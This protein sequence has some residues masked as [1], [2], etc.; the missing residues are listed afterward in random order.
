MK[1][2]SDGDLLTVNLAFVGVGPLV[3]RGKV[4]S[5]T[6]LSRFHNSSAG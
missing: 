6:I 4:D 5:E 3:G 1:L 2:R